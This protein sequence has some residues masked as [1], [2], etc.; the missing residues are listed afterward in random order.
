MTLQQ[1]ITE[2][3]R[4]SV[5]RL[6]VAVTAVA[7]TIV[8]QGTTT[9]DQALHYKDETLPIEA[10]V[11]DLLGRMTLDEK[12]GQLVQAD[13]NWLEIPHVSKFFLGSVLSGGDSEV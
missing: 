4:A 1:E 12:I 5:L 10:R 7:T 2:M 11:K 9:T 13:S 3:S 6:A 8:G